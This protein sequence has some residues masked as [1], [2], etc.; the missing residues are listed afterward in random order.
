MDATIRSRSA[1]SPGS[2]PS[3]IHVV[4]EYRASTPMTTRRVEVSTAAGPGSS[5]TSPAGSRSVEGDARGRVVEGGLRPRWRPSFV[6]RD[7]E[8]H[9]PGLCEVGGQ[10]RR[11]SIRRATGVHSTLRSWLVINVPASF[12][13]HRPCHAWN[14][15][16]TGRSS[17]QPSRGSVQPSHPSAPGTVVTV[18]RGGRGSSRPARCC[19]G[20]TTSNPPTAAATT[21]RTIVEAWAAHGA[22]PSRA[23]R[24]VREDLLR[25]APARRPSPRHR[26]R[27]RSARSRSS[28][29]C[30]LPPRRR[31][32]TAA[33]PCL[34][35]H[36][37]PRRTW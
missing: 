31:A 24:V 1:T 21:T 3:A 23:G 12:T 9:E 7:P 6:V 35:P 34:G 4:T 27:P 11:W 16:A 29:G 18:R 33:A 15:E 10:E 25:G 22:G 2:A 32:P 36:A 13:R 19:G 30:R 20:R 37:C 8:T 14:L 26:P 5:A 17:V 28:I